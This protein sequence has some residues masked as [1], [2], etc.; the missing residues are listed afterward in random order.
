MKFKSYLDL[1]PPSPSSAFAEAVW[2]KNVMCVLCPYSYP[3]YI[4]ICICFTVW[5]G[6]LLLQNIWQF[7]TLKCD[8]AFRLSSFHFD[9]CIVFCHL[10]GSLLIGIEVVSSF[11]ANKNSAAKTN[12]VNVPLYTLVKISLRYRIRISPQ[13]RM[14]ISWILQVLH[15]TPMNFHCQQHV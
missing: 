7:W 15:E 10:S 14:Y 12:F 9:C 2:V 1:F 6:I 11:I 13:W 5:N 4:N 8:D 3:T